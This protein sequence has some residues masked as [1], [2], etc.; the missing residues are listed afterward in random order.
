LGLKIFYM[1]YSLENFKKLIENLDIVTK[2]YIFSLRIAEKT[3]ALCQSLKVHN[4][5]RNKINII[6]SFYLAG[7]IA[8]DKLGKVIS[9][10]LQVDETTGNTY[11][12]AIIKEFESDRAQEGE[13][14]PQTPV[15]KPNLSEELLHM[16][17][18]RIVPPSQTTT[19]PA[20]Q[21]PAVTPTQTPPIVPAKPMEQPVPKPV[22]KPLDTEIM[23]HFGKQAAQTQSAPPQ[24]LPIH[25]PQQ[26][27]EQPKIEQPAPPTPPQASQPEPIPQ[28]TYTPHHISRFGS[29]MPGNQSETQKKDVRPTQSVNEPEPPFIK[30]APAPQP[31][32]AILAQKPETQPVPEVEQAN[33][34]SAE[35]Y[36]G[37]D[38]YREPIS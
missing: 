13:V 18:A 5:N 28:Y 32:S 6:I 24:N 27:F 7:Q 11:A 14:A 23:S 30:P 22:S 2:D 19:P 15:T 16:A 21:P 17:G 8:D 37:Q 26:S 12:D 33:E 4:E 36:H 29:V 1:Q 34:K 31:E 9:D 38:P 3:M 20:P 10:E 35:S 25:K